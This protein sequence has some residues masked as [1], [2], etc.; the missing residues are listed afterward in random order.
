SKFD[1][2]GKF[3]VLYSPTKVANIALLE[4]WNTI[5]IFLFYREYQEYVMLERFLSTKPTFEIDR[6]SIGFARMATMAS[7]YNLWIF[8]EVDFTLKKYDEQY[9]K[10]LFSTPLDLIL[11]PKEYDIRFM[12][13][14]QNQLF[15]CDFNS[16]ILVFDLFGNYKKRLPFNG[17]SYFSFYNDFITFI[18][19]NEIVLFDLYGLSETRLPLPTGKIYSQ[20]LVTGK[21]IYLFSKEGMDIYTYRLPN[22]TK[23]EK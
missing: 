8:D 5:K 17:L 12:R 1:E 16:G 9:Y 22:G 19:G 21:Y 2:E 14:Y 7:D 4:A 15:I 18:S 3:Q 13:E 6:N 20:A 10:V 23:Q 11:K